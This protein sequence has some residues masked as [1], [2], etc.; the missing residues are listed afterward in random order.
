MLEIVLL[1]FLCKSLGSMLRE[2]GYQP[3]AFQILLVVFWFG[4]EFLG[5]VVAA[6]VHVMRHGDAPPEFGLGIYLFAIVGAACGAG[7]WFLIASL[8]PP[9][10]QDY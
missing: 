1:Y 2:K 8:M 3:L 4:G 9:K 6:V 5:G 10:H 7:L